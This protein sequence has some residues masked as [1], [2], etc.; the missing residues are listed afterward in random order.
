MFQKINNPIEN[1][2]TAWIN[3]QDIRNDDLIKLANEALGNQITTISFQYTPI[4]QAQR[5]YASLSW[6]L[7]NEEKQ[8]IVQSIYAKDNQTALTKLKALLQ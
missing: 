5:K 1:L 6:H 7:T 4:R 8:H 3:M 2:Q